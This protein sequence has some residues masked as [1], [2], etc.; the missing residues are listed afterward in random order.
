MSA[1]VEKVVSDTKMARDQAVARAGESKSAGSVM[2]DLM[3]AQNLDYNV[4][5]SGNLVNSVNNVEYFFEK[6]SYAAGKQMICYLNPGD[7]M[8]HGK[9]S[10][11]VMDIEGSGPGVDMKFPSGCGTNVVDT[12]VLTT[13]KGTEI[14]REEDVADR[15]QLV[16]PATHSQDWLSHYGEVMGFD[17][18]HNYH[19][20]KRRVVI[21]LGLLCGFFNE[22]KLIPASLTQGLR[23][24]IK[25][26]TQDVAF[27][28]DNAANTY[29]VT[30]AKIVL[31]QH[32][33]MDSAIAFLSQQASSQGLQY[34]FSSYEHVGQS[35][36]TDTKVNVSVTRALSKTLK[37][38]FKARAQ[39]NQVFNADSLAS[40]SSDQVVDFQVNLGGYFEPSNKMDLSGNLAEEGF[41]YTQENL[42]GQASMGTWK[43]NDISYTDFKNALYAHFGVNLTRS[44]KLSGLEI[45][46]SK[47]LQWR[48]GV[49][50]AI[51]QR[52]DVFVEHL[53]LITSTLTKEVVQD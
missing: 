36:S 2:G 28:S 46:S 10:Y 29:T 51:S 23:V 4:R 24:A 14:L 43:S 31:Q 5:E 53:K 13:S 27:N 45:A 20:N 37:T 15:L 8:V 33:L 41:A 19:N 35:A 40:A 17:T 30:D 9:G 16:I 26:N 1:S 39:G 47:Q 25:L 34:I 32:L 12:I 44:N 18:D 52:Y 11:L 49:K 21:P 48:I 7:E 38:Y 42:W 22:D 50:G 3:R 6:S